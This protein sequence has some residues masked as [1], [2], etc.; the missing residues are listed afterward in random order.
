LLDAKVCL[1]NAIVKMPMRKKAK[2]AEEE[3]KLLKVTC[4]TVLHILYVMATIPTKISYLQMGQI[5]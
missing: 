5:C 1:E 3:R 2:E 4:I